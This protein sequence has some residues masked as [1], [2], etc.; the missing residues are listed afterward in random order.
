MYLCGLRWE[1]I[2]ESIGDDLNRKRSIDQKDVNGSELLKNNYE[3][4]HVYLH[5][6]TIPADKASSYFRKFSLASLCLINPPISLLSTLPW[7]IPPPASLPHTQLQ[8]L[9]HDHR[10]T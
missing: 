8:V 1:F 4:I 5:L 6:L 9:S 3:Q 10:Q 2:C 7:P